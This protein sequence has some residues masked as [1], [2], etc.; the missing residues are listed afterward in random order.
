M[1]G[2]NRFSRLGSPVVLF[3][4]FAL[5]FTASVGVG[6]RAAAQ[7]QGQG[8]GQAPAAAAAAAGCK[9]AKDCL[10]KGALANQKK[11][12]ANA[13]KFLAVGCDIEPKAC[14][15]VGELYRLGQGVAKDGPKAASFHQRACD[16]GLIVSC[17]IEAQMRYQ[18]DDG[19]T[20]DKARARVAYEKSCSPE[21]LDSCANAG[22]MYGA[23]DGGEVDKE[24]ARGLYQKACDGGEQTGCVNVAA[25]YLNGDGGPQ[26]KTRA[27][28]LFEQACEKKNL[29]GCFNAGLV[30]AKGLD[31]AQDLNT[32]LTFLQKSCDG[33]HKK[34]CELAQQ[35]RD[36]QAKQQ[37]AQ[38]AKP[39]AKTKKH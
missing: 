9:D 39:A 37:A 32:A 20:V 13:A 3:G 6:Q 5:F 22:V 2:S 7:V 29:L 31:G 21:F 24:K 26:D 25:M 34:S 23:G 38:A 30:Y 4:G 15:I 12:F 17:A 18:G 10:N 16:K 11:D 8:Q 14:N 35:I 28:T 33:G 36:D 1:Y 19:V 27:R